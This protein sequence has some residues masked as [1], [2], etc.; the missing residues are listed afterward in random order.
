[1][2][3]RSLRRTLGTVAACALFTSFA[4]ADDLAD[5]ADLQFR[6]GAERYTA[7]D[8]RGALEHFLASNRLVPNRNVIFNVARTYEQL[9]KFPEAFRY[10][11]AA[12]AEESDPDAKARIERA[13]E[14]IRPHVAVV[15]VTTVP[16]GA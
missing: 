2:A 3:F 11:G 10:Y 9:G 16:P 13:I 8:Y 14:Q 6:L 1:M 4:H 7:G 15:N 5:E 12:L